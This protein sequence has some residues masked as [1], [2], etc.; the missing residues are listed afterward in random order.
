M[1]RAPTGQS[2]GNNANDLTIG[3]S[4]T[5]NLPDLLHKAA[6]HR[7]PVV[8]VESH[9]QS[10][11]QWPVPLP[12]RLLNCRLSYPGGIPFEFPT[13]VTS[14]GR[15]IGCPGVGPIR[16][17]HNAGL[18]IMSVEA[19]LPAHQVP[20]PASVGQRTDTRPA[21]PT[22][23]RCHSICYIKRSCSR[24]LHGGYRSKTPASR[25]CRHPAGCLCRDLNVLDL[26]GTRRHR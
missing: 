7:C 23:T 22:S 14:S 5:A 25:R 12:R 3:Q 13:P 20:A 18:A 24:M 10:W 17:Y 8:T 11:P 6:G 21:G 15:W 26:A 4:G 19:K 16:G 9:S 1:V 2:I